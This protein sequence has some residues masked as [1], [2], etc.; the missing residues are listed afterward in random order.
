MT[1]FVYEFLYRG[2]AANDPRPTAW[3][4]ELRDDTMPN[5]AGDILNMTQAIEQG[6][7]QK[8]ITAEMNLRAVSDKVLSETAQTTMRDQ[9][10]ELNSVASA[11]ALQLADKSQREL[12]TAAQMAEA[13]AKAKV[14]AEQ[15]SDANARADA[16]EAAVEV[17]NDQLA[18]L[19]PDISAEELAAEEALPVEEKKSLLAK[20]SLGLLGGGS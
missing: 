1:Q 2:R 14:L 15:V 13:E 17:L 3:H 19:Q 16:A 20:L 11:T 12:D 5:V 9:L 4:L 8:A 7:D 10:L 18:L 6:W